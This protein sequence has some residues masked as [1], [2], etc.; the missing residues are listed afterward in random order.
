MQANSSAPGQPRRRRGRPR[1]N[2]SDQTTIR[3]RELVGS[4]TGSGAF[5]ERTIPIHAGSFS[6][7]ALAALYDEYRYSRLQVQLVPRAASS[8][9]GNVFA[10][11]YL[12][13]PFT[14][15]TLAEASQLSRF[16]AGPAFGRNTI[17]TSDTQGRAR[18]WYT[19]EATITTDEGIDPDIVQT[20]L[21]LG[22]DSV[23]SGV[24]AVDVYI[25]YTLHLRGSSPNTGGG[26]STLSTF[27]DLR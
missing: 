25:S 2:R 3:R 4:I 15:T 14:L 12:Q 19:S 21:M 1:N 11:W 24:T 17:S 27:A 8:T 10:A 23:Q 9:L 22:S 5:Q 26:A 13:P 6:G 18:R 20:W 7:G 16:S